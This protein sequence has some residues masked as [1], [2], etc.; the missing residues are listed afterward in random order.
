[1][2]INIRLLQEVTL[3]SK[4]GFL[5]VRHVG[6]HPATPQNTRRVH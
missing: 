5:S 1:M 2:S 3:V 6:I 4:L